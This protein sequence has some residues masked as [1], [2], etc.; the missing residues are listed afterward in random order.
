MR[1]RCPACNATLCEYATGNVV[2]R[3]RGRLIVVART[4]LAALQCWR[5][6]AVLSGERVRELVAARGGEHGAEARPAH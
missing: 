4:A 3:H 2:I 6:G 5:C 1:L